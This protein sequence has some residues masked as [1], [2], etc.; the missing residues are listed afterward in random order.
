[1]KKKKA[2]EVSEIVHSENFL[3]LQEKAERLR[4]KRLS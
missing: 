1:M 2:E 3:Q 4:R